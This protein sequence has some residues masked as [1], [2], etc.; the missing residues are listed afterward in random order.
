MAAGGI[1]AVSLPAASS[2]AAVTPKTLCQ[3]Q[4]AA[5]DSRGYTAENNEWGSG[6]PECITTDGGAGFTVAKSS[7]ANSTYGAPGGYPALYKGC[8]WGAC[9]PG[10]GFPIQVSDIR[11]GRVTTSWSTAQPGGSNDY[12]V[13][14]DIWFNKT[15]TATGQPNGTELMIWL[16]H[17]GPVQPFGSKVASNVS[18]GGRGYNV[19]FGNQGWNTVSYTMT[20]G[21]TSVSNLDLQP[22][23]ADAISRGYISPSWYLIDV[24]AGF[25][26]WHGGAGLATHSFSV[27]VAGRGVPAPTPIQTSPVS[28]SAPAIPTPSSTPTGPASP[29]APASPTS[30]APAGPSS[31]P[32]SPAPTGP[33]NISLQAISPSPSSSGTSTNVTVDFKN[34]GSTMASNLTLVTK[35]LNSAG[36]VVGS[37][38]QTGQNVAPQSTLNVSYAWSADSTAGTYTV[39]ALVQDSSGK[40][41]EHAKVGTVTVK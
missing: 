40:T 14:Y 1:V 41:L 30:P 5:V 39:E 10:S 33:V 7:I 34:L 23:I 26:L 32:T 15:P 31:S 16:N 19:W 24:E 36:K 25:E 2:E 29:S 9:T 21:T 35:I 37:Q 12:D 17:N 3:S 4:T 28:Q 8:H 11:P 27:K 13:A 18:I 20:S 22:L 38:S 6:E